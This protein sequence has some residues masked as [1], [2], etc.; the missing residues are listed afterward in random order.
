MK[1]DKLLIEVIRK[2]VDDI[3]FSN[4]TFNHFDSITNGIEKY[5]GSIPLEIR[6]L[7]SM[8]K[9]CDVGDKKIKDIL[10][11][12]E[13]KIISKAIIEYYLNT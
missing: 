1:E 11:S 7:K 5:P 9:N 10:T 2:C 13:C 4:K 6:P 3:D 8:I 12:K